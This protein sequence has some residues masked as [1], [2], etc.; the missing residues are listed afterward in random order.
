MLNRLTPVGPAEAYKTYA[1]TSPIATHF[2]AATCQEIDCANYANG[3]D[4]P[5]DTS[6]PKFAEA[7][8]WIRLKS[9]RT[10]TTTEAGPIVTFRF[11]PGQQCFAQHKVPLERPEIYVVRGGDW[12]GNPRGTAPVQRKAAD[13]LDDFATHQDG[14]RAAIERG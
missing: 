10:F 3:W 13:W 9:R 12:R 7:A 11:P 14:L 2:R 5:L 4:S 8:N 1:I 6:V